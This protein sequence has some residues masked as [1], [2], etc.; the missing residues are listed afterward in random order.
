[1]ID[2]TERCRLGHL[3]GLGSGRIL[4][5]GEP[6][7]L[8]IEHHYVEANV[9]TQSMDEVVASDTQRITIAADHPDVE[10]RPCHGEACGN[11]RRTPMD[12]VHS[13]GVH[14]VRESRRTADARDEHGLFSAHPKVGHHHLDRRQDVVVPAPRTPADFLVRAP[15]LAGGQGNL[16]GGHQFSPIA[17]RMAASISAALKG[18]PRTFDKGLASIR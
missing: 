13:V 10:I 3:A 4:A 16:H 15:V 1:M 5:L 2:R 9:P 6:V 7:D 11:R 17:E 14:V 12:R 8:V 18:T